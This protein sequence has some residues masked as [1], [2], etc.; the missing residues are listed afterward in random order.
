MSRGKKISKKDA[1]S[2]M[3]GNSE[4]AG[5][6]KKLREFLGDRQIDFARR[7]K[8]TQPMVSAWEAGSDTPSSAFLLRFG[9]MA[10]YP[11]NFWF[12]EQAG[13]DVQSMTKAARKLTRERSAAPAPGEIIRLPRFR[14]TLQGRESAGLPI[15]LPTEFIPKPGSMICFVVDKQATAIVN[16][17]DGVFLLDESENDAPNLLPFWGQD[18]FV[19]YDPEIGTDLH[20]EG[21]IYAGRLRVLHSW[22]MTIYSGYR[23]HARLF[24]STDVTGN[25]IVHVGSW[26]PVSRTVLGDIGKYDPDHPQS[27]AV[28]A[29]RKQVQERALREIKL[30]RGWRILGRVRGRL[31]LKGAENFS[32]EAKE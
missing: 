2:A 10:P 7:L 22:P 14:E 18:V 1:G 16:S 25:Q 27:E 13:I 20:H 31:K 28:M 6:V 8:V 4:S 26:G 19:E 21:G 11:D 12:W 15:P 30:D 32:G 5:Q 3:K 24:L 17:P 29:T 23:G 9:N